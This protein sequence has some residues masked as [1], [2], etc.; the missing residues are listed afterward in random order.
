MPTSSTIPIALYR[1]AL[2]KM[3]L[4]Q[5]PSKGGH[6]KWTRANLNRPV[7]F[8]N[9]FKEIPELQVKS[10]CRTLGISL[11]VFMKLVNSL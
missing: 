3:G 2:L 7:M 1:K 8:S 4:K 6:E 11:H 10:N 5:M 9:H